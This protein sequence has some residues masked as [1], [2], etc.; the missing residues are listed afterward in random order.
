MFVSVKFSKRINYVHVYNE[1]IHFH[2]DTLESLW[3]LPQYH[4]PKCEPRWKKT[5]NLLKQ[6]LN[7]CCFDFSW[8]Q[9]DWETQ[10]DRQE[11]T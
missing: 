4:H 1:R 2:C 10:E 3:F 5:Q 6:R 8:D 9:Y 11:V 7:R